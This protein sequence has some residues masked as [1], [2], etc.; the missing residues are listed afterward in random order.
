MKE[1]A[2]QNEKKK[3]YSVIGFILVFVIGASI[4]FYPRI[5]YWLADRNHVVA[6]QSYE[7]SVADLTKDEKQAMWD[8]AVLY[9]NRLVDSVVKDP[10][11]A[12]KDI[13][14][15]DEYDETLDVGDGEMGYIHIPSINVMIPI[16]HGV[17]EEVLDK[18]IG[19]IKATALPVGG[20]G[21]HSV[22]TGHSGLTHAEMFN[23]LEQVKIKDQFFLQILDETLAYEVRRI[24]VVLP[25]DVS[26]LHRETGKDKV[27][28][29]TCTPYGVN[30][31]RLLVMG[32]RVPVVSPMPKQQREESPQFPW[33][34]IVLVIVIIIVVITIGRKISSRAKGRSKIC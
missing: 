21:T 10:F 30:S 1:P 31:H 14:P 7:R 3:N 26:L 8:K 33:W 29:I 23:D 16:Y 13:A 17:S 5:S 22:L 25:D 12:T 27:T 24:E 15:F 32:E 18:G 11:A 28:L 9:N 4:L 6:H 34:I 20:A 2:R 19:H